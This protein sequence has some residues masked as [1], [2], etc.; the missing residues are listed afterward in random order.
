VLLERR[1][2][3]APELPEDDRE[4]KREAGDKAHLDRR[5]EGLGDAERHELS[6]ACG[7]KRLREPA[8]D[9]VLEG[10][11][12]GEPASDGEKGED[13]PSAKL[14]EVL[15]EGDALGVG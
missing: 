7:G 3:E 12:P 8:E 1:R 10:E 5:E 11:R 2:E 14:V 15:D 4:R 9:V 6:L 13:E